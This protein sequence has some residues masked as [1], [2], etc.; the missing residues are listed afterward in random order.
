MKMD[1]LKNAFGSTPESVKECVLRSLREEPRREF[2]MKKKRMLSLAIALAVVL[3][4]GCAGFAATQLEGIARIFGFT[5][6]ETGETV[7]NEAALRHITALNEV[8]EGKT[9]RFTLTEGMYSPMNSN[10]A[11]GWTLEPLTEGEMY[12]VLCDVQVGGMYMGHM[13]LSRVTEYILSGAE[14]CALSGS[15]S[16]ESLLTELKFSILKLKGEPVRFEGWD[17]ENETEEEFWA[18]S[19]ALIAEGKLPM[20]GDG[21]IEVRPSRD[22]TYAEE[23]VRAGAAELAE[24]FTVSFDLRAI[25]PID[26]MRVYEGEKTFSFD[27]FEVQ[28]TECTVTPADSRISLEILCDEEA[29]AKDIVRG[30]FVRFCPPGEEYWMGAACPRFLAPVRTGDGRWKVSVTYDVMEQLVY[31]EELILSIAAADENENPILLTGD[32]ILLKLTDR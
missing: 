22:L 15:V 19:D 28:I 12:Y 10:L 32:G 7:V 29:L 24:E 6:H 30:G 9:V 27:G 17:D 18:R 2:V 4:L 13:T 8:Y 25:S 1:D 5:N 14:R 21:V 16:G 3:A 20:A 26:E 11:L 23:L 31:P